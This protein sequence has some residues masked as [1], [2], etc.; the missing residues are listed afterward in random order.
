MLDAGHGKIVDMLASNIGPISAGVTSTVATVG[1]AASAVPPPEGL[2]VWAAYGLSILGPVFILVAKR[3]LAAVAASKRA[4]AKVKED[5]A[6]ALL[7]DKD[8]KNDAE[9]HALEEDAA[10]DRASADALE[11]LS[12]VKPE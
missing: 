7:A 2:P 10:G 9:A 4:K 3:V 8:P 6:R 12:R 1:L 11:A 5:R